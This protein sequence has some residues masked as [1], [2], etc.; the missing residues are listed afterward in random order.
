MDTSN[1]SQDIVTKLDNLEEYKTETFEA[2]I[3]IC[4]ELLNVARRRK[5][6]SLSSLCNYYI[7]R[8]YFNMR[9]CSECVRYL[10]KS[11]N[12]ANESNAQLEMCRSLVLLAST[13]TRQGNKT[14]AMQTLSTVIR[15]A[16]GKIAEHGEF[17][18][19]LIR[20]YEDLSDVCYTIGN[21]QEGLKYQLATERLF[22]LI[23]KERFFPMYYMRHL[24][25]LV[26]CY[27]LLGD[28][29]NA[30]D[31]ISQ[32]DNFVQENKNTVLEPYVSVSHII[33]NE[34]TGD[35]KWDD[36]YIDKL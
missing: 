25:S 29:T 20:S 28:T 26:R 35:H 15:I 18:H 9:N 16:E 3:R 8:Y 23:N 4:N 11:I 22:Y 17:G 34:Y 31:I 14:N 27:V 13:F 6:K 12:E 19:I 30:G 1:Y 10:K 7:A 5:D 36:V 2:T 33:W 32:I 24:C 21:Y